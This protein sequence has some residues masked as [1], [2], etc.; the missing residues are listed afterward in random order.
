V[1]YDGLTAHLAHTAS[2]SA[3]AARDAVTL[4][5]ENF[6]KEQRPYLTIVPSGGILDP[7]QPNNFDAAFI[8][9][10]NKDGSFSVSIAAQIFDTGKTAAAEVSTTA[11]ESFFDVP[12]KAESMARN[13]VPKYQPGT[14]YISPGS[15]PQVPHGVVRTIP[16]AQ[17]EDF[18]QGKMSLFIVGAVRY[19]DLF[20]TGTTYE[21]DYCY[22][23]S[24]IGLPFSLCPWDRDFHNTLK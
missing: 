2:I 15:F 1:I 10:P 20:T 17:W 12:P 14:N 8:A 11:T 22:Q 18:K 21:T 3:D 5:T 13:Y 24:P 4:A 7:R 19:S 16:T 6:K 9:A 23:I